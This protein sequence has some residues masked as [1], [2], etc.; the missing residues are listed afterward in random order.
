MKLRVNGTEHEVAAPDDMPLLWVLRDLLG[1]TGTKYGCGV[2]QCGACLVHVDGE[3]RRSCMTRAAAV[4]GKSV[5]TIEGLADGAELHPVQ[6][7]FVEHGGI[8]CGFCTP[9]MILGATAL[10]AANPAPDEHQIR[11]ALSGNLC[12]CTG[13]QKIVESVGA[14]ADLL[15]ARKG[16]AR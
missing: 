12:R 11:H 3:P 1:L 7:A 16:D 15:A 2:G 8:Q 13:Y 14:A 4:A 6:Q 5:T 10:L 9:G